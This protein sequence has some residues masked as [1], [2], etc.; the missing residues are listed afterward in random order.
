MEAGPTYGKGC[1]VS[2]GGIVLAFLAAV[3]GYGTRSSVAEALY[4]G[5]WL[6]VLGGVVVFV[7]A[8]VRASDENSLPPRP[9]RARVPTQQEFDEHRRRIAP[10]GRPDVTEPDSPTPP[11]D[12]A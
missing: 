10:D 11:R 12:R 9:P 7:M 3:G 4:A 5:G 1:L 8:M 2:L 6:A